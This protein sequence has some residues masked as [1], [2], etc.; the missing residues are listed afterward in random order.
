MRVFVF[1]LGCG[2]LAGG[3][4]FGQ[5]PSDAQ[6]PK[7][8]T[9]AGQNEK[10]PQESAEQPMSFWMSKKLEYS[11]SLFEQLTK[12]DFELLEREAIRLRSLGKMEGLVRRKNPEYVTQLQ[13][14][15]T[16]MAELIRH[17]RKKNPEGAVLAFNHM[18]T[19]CV[20]CH[21]LIRQGVE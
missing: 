16:A 3:A 11:K 20:A 19:S 21:I 17:A 4:W 14:F 2:L 10:I 8:T 18:T 5:S 1:L 9:V 7:R 15:D 6:E 12:G 13:T